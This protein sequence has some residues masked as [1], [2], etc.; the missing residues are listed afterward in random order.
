MARKILLADDSVTAQNMGR[1]I[2][3]DA[4]YDVITVNNG[5]AALKKIAELKPELIILDVYMPGYSGLEV[6]QRLKDAHETARIPVLLSVGKLEPFKP[7]E[8]KRVRAEGYIVKPFEASELLSALSKLEDKIVPKAEAGKAGRLNRAVAIDESSRSGDEPAAEGSWKSRISFPSKK[9]E[10]AEES[11]DDGALYNAVN[12]D[13][14]TVVQ[15]NE[16][17]TPSTPV[18]KTK[19]E[20]V[21]LGALATPGLPKDVTTEE[22]AALAAAA[23]HVQGRKLEA[24][25][26]ALPVEKEIKA[27]ETAVSPEPA[28]EVAET[29]VAEEVVAPQMRPAAQTTAP[30][31]PTEDEV[32]AAIASLET[33]HSPENLR[34]VN[35]GNGAEPASQQAEDLPVTMAVSPVSVSEGPRWIAV[36]VPV[37]AQ[38]AALSLEH[39]MQSAFRAFSAAAAAQAGPATLVDE[40]QSSMIETAIAPVTPETMVETRPATDSAIEPR[41]EPVVTAP[42]EVSAEASGNEVSSHEQASSTEAAEFAAARGHEVADYSEQQDYSV[43]QQLQ[44]SEVTQGHVDDATSETVKSELPTPTTM[45][46]SA[47]SEAA[48]HDVSQEQVIGTESQPAVAASGEATSPE[49]ASSEMT[50]GE[51]IASQSTSAEAGVAEVAACENAAAI[52]QPAVVAEAP[53]SETAEAAIGVPHD[54]IEQK[55]VV[56]NLVVQNLIEEKPVEQDRVSAENVSPASAPQLAP[57]AQVD[58]APQTIPQ[59][60]ESQVAATTAAAWASWR[61]IRDSVPALKAPEPAGNVNEEQTPDSVAAAAFAAAAGAETS[62]GV[63]SSSAETTSAVNSQTVA[64]IVDSLLAELRPRIVEEI[65]RK[66]AVEKK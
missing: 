38:E 31:T 50:S 9:K 2:L 56:Q 46:V 30:V 44:P 28:R 15:R 5:S 66:L 47:P 37:D 4:G 26:A 21:D 63:S 27:E 39:E 51:T 25:S 61:Q 62:P 22:I 6:C 29:P 7:D 10:Q 55:P 13:L 20:R 52:E 24:E 3:A 23:A 12:R 54:I 14:K 59:S 11:S 40:T 42:A 17:E 18:E 34:N 64:S 53:A 43:T 33:E 8:A 36:S 16:P 32:S 60:N 57:S 35:S 19:E 58:A 49:L 41:T 45:E 65:S 1:K 48:T